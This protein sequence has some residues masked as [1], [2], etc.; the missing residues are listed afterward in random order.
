[1]YKTMKATHYI[2]VLFA[3]L[4]TLVCAGCED[5]LNIESMVVWEVLKITTK[6]T[7]KLRLPWLLCLSLGVICILTGFM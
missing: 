1:M 3:A 6:L 7:R 5:R 4:F 2:Y